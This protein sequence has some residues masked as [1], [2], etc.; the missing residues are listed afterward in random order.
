MVSISHLLLSD[1]KSNEK[2]K[3]HDKKKDKD[4]KD[5]GKK[6]KKGK[7]VDPLVTSNNMSVASSFIAVNMEVPDGQ[8]TARKLPNERAKEQEYTTLQDFYNYLN[9]G[10][11]VPFVSKKNYML[12]LD[13]RS[14]EE[15]DSC[16][17]ATSRH[18]SFLEDPRVVEQLG[19][20]KKYS[21]VII[22][23][24]NGRTFDLTMSTLSKTYDQL[25]A[26]G[27]EP[28][29]IEG[30]FTAFF[31][32]FPFLCTN[33]PL[34]S[35]SERLKYF[36]AYPTMLV[37]N[38]LYLGSAKQAND[39]DVISNLLITH[40]INASLEHMNAFT[41]KVSYL[42]IDEDEDRGFKLL[43][44][45]PEAIKFIRAAKESNGTALI[46]CHHGVNRSTIIAVA[47]LMY[48]FHWS[49][50]DS[51]GYLIRKRQVVKLDR[52]ALKQLSRFEN[53]LF[54]CQLTD[55]DEIL[56]DD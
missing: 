41:D 26:N 44:R 29:I 12:L 17:I 46:H 32:K 37:E 1:K 49:L 16:H 8:F 36:V 9:D 13:T 38:F 20:I 15:F 52:R 11:D 10:G 23:D 7:K 24:E 31:N 28:L 35:H 3:K 50:S 5:K 51:Y 6:D 2:K 40:D 56:E 22:Y 19:S 48:E 53:R 25:S 34:Q 4:K 30:G 18:Y 21:F 54:G 33:R 42:R 55:I 43:P 14:R 27:V 47:V 39:E 45:F